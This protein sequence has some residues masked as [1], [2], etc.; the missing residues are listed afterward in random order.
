MDFK[1]IGASDEIVPLDSL[2]ANERRDADGLDLGAE[3]GTRESPPVGP[4]SHALL[5]TRWP[6][7][8]VA[9]VRSAP[10]GKLP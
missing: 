4:A 7:D 5:A 6:G 8:A 1:H 9:R 10:L 2:P 3:E